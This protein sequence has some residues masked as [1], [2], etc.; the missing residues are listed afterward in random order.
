MFFEQLTDKE[1]YDTRDD[2][3]I[4][5]LKDKISMVKEDAEQEVKNEILKQ[6]LLENEIQRMRTKISRAVSKDEAKPV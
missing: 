1:T 6:E 4:Q 3:E 5:V 2:L